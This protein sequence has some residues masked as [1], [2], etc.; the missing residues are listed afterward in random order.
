MKVLVTDPLAPEG[1]AILRDAGFEV[2]VR[3]GLAPE[4]LLT[5]IAGCDALVVRSGT[6]VTADVIEAAGRLKVIGRAGA[7]V[8]NVDVEAATRCGILVMNT[9]GGNSVSAAELA[10]AMMLALAR[11]LPQ[12]TTR[13]RAGDWPRK[14]FIGTELCGKRLGIIGLGR[15]GCEVARRALAFGMDVVAYDPFVTEERARA[16][17]VKLVGFDILVATSDVITVHSPRNPETMGLINARAFDAMK[18]GVLLINCARGGIVDEAAL[19]A[20]LES[21][22]VAGCALDVFDQEPPSPD[23]PLL[24]FDQVIATPHVGATTREAQ[25]NVAIQIAQ[26]VADV[27][28]GGA[29]RNAIN[30]ASVDPELLEL[31]GPHIHLAEQLGR[32]VVQLADAT[33]THLTLTFRGDMIDHDMT[34][35]TTAALKGILSRALSTPVNDVNA[36]VI[37]AE[38][39]LKVDTVKS[40]DL[41]DFANLITL[42]ARTASGT[43]SVSGTIFGKN[44]PRIVRLNG[45]HVDVTPQG[46]LLVTLNH[47][48]PGVIAHVS[49]VLADRGVNIADMTCGRDVPGGSSLL[50]IS[51]DGVVGPDVLRTIEDSPV[52]RRAQHVSL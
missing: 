15:I 17:E 30:A 44:Q 34:P 49:S 36:A 8:D 28:R 47:D 48:R 1:V 11:R 3:P 33:I 50:V 6:K 13:V 42:D 4:E 52:I 27:L 40:R 20:A 26:Q 21:G 31:L 14:E 29:P 2:D 7:G 16:L 9:P 46:N 19:T 23:H 22:K 18:D 43:T 32:I 38:R 25:A 12:A 41:E 5:A 51:I 39:G 10:M 35:L 24:A 45:F 37:A